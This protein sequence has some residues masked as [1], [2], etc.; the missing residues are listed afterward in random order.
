MSP[1]D[2]SPAPS[3]PS[4]LALWW[5]PLTGLAAV[6]GGAVLADQ[7]TAASWRRIL[8][9]ACAALVLITLVWALALLR[10]LRVERRLRAADRRTARARGAEVE[11]LVT[12]RLPAIADRLRSGGR[13]DTVPGPL[14]PAAD[15]GDGFARALATVVDA[16]GSEDAVRRERA[17]RD[18][19]QAAFESVARN[20]HA[21]A[22]VQQQVLD[23]VERSIE[24]PA[25]MA[26]VMKA[27]HAAAQMTRKA[28]TLLVM[29][30]VWP[31]RRET[32]PVSL[33]D[34]VRGAQS[35][36]VEFNRIEVHG[37]QNLYAVP[38]AVEGLMHAIAELLENATVFSPSSTRVMVT[39]REVGAGAVVEIDDAGLGMPP[40]VLSQSTARLRNG[41]DLAELGAVP[42]L[43]LACVGRWTRELGFSVELSGASAYGGT[44]AVAFV[45]H[46]LLTEPL[47]PLPGRG[48]PRRD[49]RR[50]PHPE[51]APRRHRDPRPAH[52]GTERPGP[53][54]AAR[55]RTVPGYPYD[56]PAV[57]G[58][59]PEPGP[60]PAPVPSPA[61]ADLPAPAPAPD[62][63]NAPY[64]SGT[65][66]TPYTSHT[67]DAPQH[68]TAYQEPHHRP[69][70][71]GP[72]QHPSPQ[73][74]SPQ[75]AS[76]QHASPP[77]L[78]PRQPLPPEQPGPGQGLG[79]GPGPAGPAGRSGGALPRRQSRRGA[80]VEAAARTA[81]QPEPPAAPPL[82]VDRTAWTP[83]AAR[84]SITS[85]VSGSR[86]GRAAVA[87]PT[88][89][90]SPFRP[91]PADSPEPD[92]HHGGRS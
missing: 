32:R 27:D 78:S 66:H 14:A 89:P 29:C 1:D 17:L 52:G 19:V 18:A 82:P 7:Y 38:P 46:R 9:W 2:G 13:L 86:R 8:A 20:M 67:S 50:E 12:L 31:A 5:P 34:C 4:G 81:L 10:L 47:P 75:H 43:G 45:P 57:P 72:S 44:R 77:P 40:D 58:P 59:S 62:A 36:I 23:R 15:T 3:G 79:P 84:A 65:P 22:T 91:T 49:Q 26:E 90:D 16:L 39:V 87:G 28:Q 42:R 80:A 53:P 83:E 37:G 33:Y 74:P 21:M 24:D 41:L 51:Q 71:A 61:W 63:P 76:P 92:A 70:G 60:A 54:A 6:A 35:R 11:R 30:G 85:V 25:L 69:P 88:A 56:R 48:L 73:H 68:S 55:E 64:A